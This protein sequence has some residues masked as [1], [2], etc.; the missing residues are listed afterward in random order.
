M[1]QQMK[2]LMDSQK[3]ILEILKYP[4]KLEKIAKVKL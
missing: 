3:E 1:R 2:H 4:E